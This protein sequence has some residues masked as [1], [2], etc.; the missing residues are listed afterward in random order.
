MQLHW[1]WAVI[2][3]L[4]LG[5]GLI[6]WTQP[7]DDSRATPDN[8]DRHGARGRSQADA[9]PTIYRWVDAHGVVNVSN[10]HPPAGRKFT[11]VH[12]NPNQNIVP[13]SDSPSTTRS[14]TRSSVPH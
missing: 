4:A 9:A 1:G 14:T 13:M 10:E 6:W 11:I 7:A 8:P 5:A 2:G 3:A 12:I